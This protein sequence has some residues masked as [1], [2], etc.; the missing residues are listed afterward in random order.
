[1]ERLLNWKHGRIKGW[2]INGKGN[3]RCEYDID[4]LPRYRIRG[5]KGK[6]YKQAHLMVGGTLRWFYIHR[7]VGF[8]WLALP[9]SPLRFIIDHKNGDSLCNRVENLRWVTITGN[10]INKKCYGLREKDGWFSPRVASYTHSKYRTTDVELALQIRK[11]LV[12][13][14][15]RYNSRFPNCGSEFPHKY[16]YRY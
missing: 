5:K 1:M 13:C 11:L 8:S 9:D 14:Y 16:I 7:L 2:V 3:L 10:N 12:E 6:H 4:Y 15:V